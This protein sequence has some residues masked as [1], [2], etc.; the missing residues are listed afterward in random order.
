MTT[1]ALMAKTP[2]SA[3]LG[4]NDSAR[5]QR[6]C[7]LRRRR[8]RLHARQ[9][10]TSTALVTVKRVRSIVLPTSSGSGGRSRV[11]AGTLAGLSSWLIVALLLLTSFRERPRSLFS[12]WKLNHAEM[13]AVTNWTKRRRRRDSRMSPLE[14][15]A[16]IETH[17]RYN[18]AGRK[19]EPPTKVAQNVGKLLIRRGPART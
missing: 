2:A 8:Q 18:S 16:T 6:F 15:P 12:S 1:A 5:D 13:N 9:A 7:N 4:A 3:R 17:I 10:T 19:V 14:G 11:L